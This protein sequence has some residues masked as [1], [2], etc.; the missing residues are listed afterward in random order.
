MAPKF[1]EMWVAVAE[2][3]RAAEAAIDGVNEAIDSI[4]NTAVVLVGRLVSWRRNGCRIVTHR[5]Y[6]HNLAMER[7]QR[8]KP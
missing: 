7:L 5:P 8:S 3:G 2:Q 4:I 1:E 6:L